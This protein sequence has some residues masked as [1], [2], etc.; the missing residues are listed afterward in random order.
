[1]STPMHQSASDEPIGERLDLSSS[2]N[3]RRLI[4]QRIRLAWPDLH[5][6]VDEF[7]AHIVEHPAIVAE[8]RGELESIAIE[9]L[10]LAYACGQQDPVALR[11]FSREVDPELRA[12]AAKLRISDADLN[13]VRQAIWDKLF[14]GTD[15]STRKI[16]SYRGEGRLRSW[17]GALAARM[18]I[19]R[20]RQ[21]C[22][23]ELGVRRL[24]DEVLGP[25]V[26]KSDSEI[27]AMRRRYSGQFRDAFEAAAQTLEPDERNAIRCHYLLE[28]TVDQMA[29]AFGTHRATAARRVSRARSKLLA[30][31]RD[32]LKTSL[33]AESGELDSI[34]RLF[35]REVS[36]TLSRIFK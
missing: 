33:G 29:V 18:L 11:S 13:D 26:A 7:I 8:K 12:V 30:A 6:H 25:A 17:F 3:L 16:L 31:T 5:W 24:D 2:A 22:P 34:M 9:D 36:V 1:M 21:T 14:V 23:Y 19:D 10:F 20:L 28:M 4:E 35:D 15:G 32:R 27:A